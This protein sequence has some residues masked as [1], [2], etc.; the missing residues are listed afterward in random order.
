[1]IKTPF[2][3]RLKEQTRR[4]ADS[5][6]V[7]ELRDF[8]DMSGKSGSRAHGPQML[9]K[10]RQE[11]SISQPSDDVWYGNSWQDVGGNDAT[12]TKPGPG[13]RTKKWAK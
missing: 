12:T 8:R 7:A 9:M 11:A 13:V 4:P 1:M 10:K 5:G 6:H 3:Q 2:E